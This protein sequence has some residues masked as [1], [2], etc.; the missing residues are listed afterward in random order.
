MRLKDRVAIVTGGGA[1]IGRTY[2]IG[3]SKEGAKVVIA[4]INFEDAKK[5]EKEILDSG[6][7]A[8]AIKTDVSNWDSVHSMVDE[9]VK[10]YGRIDILINN[11]ALYPMK[12]WLEISEEEWDRVLAVNLKGCFIC[13]RAVFPYMKS[14]GKG[15]IINISSSTV[16][17]G[18]NLFLH[19]V[20]SKGGII[21][22]TRALARDLGDYGI[23]VNAVTPGL[24]QS[25]HIKEVTP[26]EFADQLAAQQCLKR[27]EQPED[28][29]GA[30]MF[31]AS[32]DSDF[33]TGQTIN[34][35]GGWAM[36]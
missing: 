14:Q 10:K 3:L 17:F 29:L 33:I 31:L 16:Y 6:G 35:D 15:K 19:Y 2:C 7:D 20:S 11:A 9:A 5:V 24:T 21:A 1:G 12:S 4:E 8:L 34:V 32:D 22:F 25:E 30:V 23:N 27:K 28:L 13:S 18:T 26:Q 36:H